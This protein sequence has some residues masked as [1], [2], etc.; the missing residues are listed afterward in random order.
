MTKILTRKCSVPDRSGDIKL[1]R[2]DFN[3]LYN[4]QMDIELF[5]YFEILMKE[6]YTGQLTPENL[7]K[8]KK[9]F[10]KQEENAEKQEIKFNAGVTFNPMTAQPAGINFKRDNADFMN[11]FFVNIV[12]NSFTN[13]EEI[14]RNAAEDSNAKAIKQSLSNLQKV[15]KVWR[16]KVINS[17]NKQFQGYDNV[18]QENNALIYGNEFVMKKST[19]TTVHSKKNTMMKSGSVKAPTTN[20]DHD[21]VSLRDLDEM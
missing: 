10:M 3:I 19:M 7:E 17:V 5:N 13:I 20:V 15:E 16:N 14:L 1:A 8:D 9:K 11:N 4:I 12:A 2:C 21:E 18:I 6:Y